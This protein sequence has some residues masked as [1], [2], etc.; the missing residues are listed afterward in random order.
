MMRQLTL[1]LPK[2]RIADPPHPQCSYGIRVGRLRCNPWRWDKVPPPGAAGCWPFPRAINTIC[3]GH[4]LSVISS[5]IGSEADKN[6]ASVRAGGSRSA[7]EVRALGLITR[8]APIQ[9]ASV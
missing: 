8:A 3:L 7:C 6:L 2:L 9:A 4:L 5:P 1:P